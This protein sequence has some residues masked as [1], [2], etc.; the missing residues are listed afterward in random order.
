MSRA[1]SCHQGGGGLH[2]EY[3]QYMVYPPGV[4]TRQEVYTVKHLPAHDHRADHMSGSDH[5]PRRTPHKAGHDD[6]MAHDDLESDAIFEGH[7]GA[8]SHGEHDMHEG[9]NGHGDHAG[10]ADV[11]RRR[12]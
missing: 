1:R 5:V 12:F 11:F 8:E 2:G 4:L 6:S 7:Q 3:N 9:H 10:H